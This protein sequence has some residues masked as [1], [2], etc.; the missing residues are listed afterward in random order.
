MTCNMDKT[1]VELGADKIYGSSIVNPI[2]P[3]IASDP[4]IAM[5]LRWHEASAPMLFLTE[6]GS[7]LKPDL[8]SKMRKIFQKMVERAKNI[9]RKP[10]REKYTSLKQ[11]FDC[12]LDDEILGNF[13]VQ[14][15]SDAIK[16][17]NAL[18]NDLENQW[19]AELSNI[20]A[21][22]YGSR[23]DIP[24]YVLTF[25]KGFGSVLKLMMK[26]MEHCCLRMDKPV[27][28]IKWELP[29]SL[30]R[31]VIVT[32]EN[33]E[34]PADYVIVTVSL[35]V[36]KTQAQDLFCPQLPEEKILSIDSIGFGHINKVFLQYNKAFWV[37]REPALMPAISCDESDWLD[38]VGVIE[39]VPVPDSTTLVASFAGNGAKEIECVNEYEIVKRLQR[40]LRCATGD[41]TL[42]FPKSVLRTSWSS[43]GHIGGALT[44]MSADSNIGDILRLSEPVP[45]SSPCGAPIL[46]F[47]GE[48]TSPSQ[49]GTVHGARQSGIREADRII[50]LTKLFRGLPPKMD[51]LTCAN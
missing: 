14:E 17:V 22:F 18:I 36:L 42:P 46:F 47:A 10:S 1:V 28:Y 40:L 49:Y 34:I 16:V 3:I 11:Y 41:M 23:A 32:C 5:N 43:D 15:R 39:E 31:A 24:G 35:G 13:K 7:V 48:A 37:N 21:N 26:N 50:H 20:S 45:L 38:S 27:K 8:V 4:A 29:K 25:E 2:I 12:V 19:G 30:P 9:Y 51:Q 44:Y 33:E 6:I